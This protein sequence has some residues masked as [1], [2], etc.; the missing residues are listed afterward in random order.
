MKP[1]NRSSHSSPHVFQQHECI[2]RMFVYTDQTEYLLASF[3][4]EIFEFRT[5]RCQQLQPFIRDLATPGK[6]NCFHEMTPFAETIGIS[7]IVTITIRTIITTTTTTT[8]IASS[9]MLQL[10][11]LSSSDIL[12]SDSLNHHYLKSPSS[13]NYLSEFHQHHHY[14]RRY[15]R[16]CHRPRHHHHHHHHHQSPLPIDTDMTNNMLISTSAAK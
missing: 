10:S 4:D 15:C 3:A 7:A 5:A 1:I 8:T 2:S 11:Q 12:S 6:V 16:Y 9:H 14:R 13:L